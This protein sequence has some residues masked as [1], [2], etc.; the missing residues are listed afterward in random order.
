MLEYDWFYL[1]GNLIATLVSRC[2]PVDGL[3]FGTGVSLPTQLAGQES[4]FEYVLPY[5]NPLLEAQ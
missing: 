2:F 3:A 4:S 1:Q 5:P